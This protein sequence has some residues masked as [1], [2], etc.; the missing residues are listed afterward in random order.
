MSKAL[1]IKSNFVETSLFSE[2]LQITIR[3]KPSFMAIHARIFDIDKWL[4][5]IL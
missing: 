1:R 2:Q 5:S 4:N 3:K